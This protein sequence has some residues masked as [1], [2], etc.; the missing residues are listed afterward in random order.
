MTDIF[1]SIASM[2]NEVRFKICNSKAYRIMLFLNTKPNFNLRL[3]S[4]YEDTVDKID[5]WQTMPDLTELMISLKIRDPRKTYDD[6]LSELFDPYYRVKDL[7]GANKIGRDFIKP[8]HRVICLSYNG[9]TIR[10]AN[11]HKNWEI[12][13]S[14]YNQLLE[15][16]PNYDSYK[17][18]YRGY[19]TKFILDSK[20]FE[21]CQLHY[22]K[23]EKNG[24]PKLLA[25][26]PTWVFEKT[27]D[28]QYFTWKS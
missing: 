27:N 20:E 21:G 4:T 23:D 16:H 3:A 25:F 15:E 26:V 6:I 1:E 22:K 14:M 17:A 11:G 12:C 9:I 7:C 24:L 28:I 10:D 13:S 8:Y 19:P 18:P 5:C 2:P